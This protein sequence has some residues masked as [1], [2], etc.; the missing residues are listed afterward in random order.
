MAQRA[1]ALG[2]LLLV[3][4]CA[5]LIIMLAML[6]TADTGEVEPIPRAKSDAVS[7]NWNWFRGSQPIQQA[8]VVG[9]LENSTL[10]AKLLGVMISREVL[11]QPWLLMANRKRS[12]TLVISWDPLSLLKR[13]NRTA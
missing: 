13:L 5:V 11:Q 4:I 7:L 10:K 9:E 2:N 12:T 6:Y 3:L 1:I 8:P